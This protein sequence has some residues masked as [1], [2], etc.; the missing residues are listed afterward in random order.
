MDVKSNKDGLKK[1]H[2][3]IYDQLM[4]YMDPLALDLTTRFNSSAQQRD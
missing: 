2:Q 1:Y 3:D 4:A